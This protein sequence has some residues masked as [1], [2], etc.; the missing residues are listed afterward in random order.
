M[1]RVCN[2]AGCHRLL[3]SKDGE[4]DYRKRFC[5][6]DCLRADKHERVLAKRNRLSDR[7]CPYCHRK[8]S[9]IRPGIGL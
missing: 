3:V 5:S 2:R 4:P 6:P 7:P 1:P 8:R 9:S